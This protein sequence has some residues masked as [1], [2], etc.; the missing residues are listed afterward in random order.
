MEGLTGCFGLKY[1]DLFSLSSAFSFAEKLIDLV[2]E[3]QT[4]DML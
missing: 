2:N 4:G 1:W 3:L